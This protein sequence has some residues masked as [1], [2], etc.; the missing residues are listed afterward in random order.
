MEENPRFEEIFKED[1]PGNLARFHKPHCA[2]LFKQLR[3]E[4]GM[5]FLKA[6]IVDG[7]TDDTFS[8]FDLFDQSVFKGHN[9]K[10]HEFLASII[11]ENENE[12]LHLAV[13]SSNLNWIEILIRDY[14][15]D[16]NAIIDGLTPLFKVHSTPLVELKF[17]RDH[18][19]NSSRIIDFL[20]KS[21]ADPLIEVDAFFSLGPYQVH[22]NV[23]F[24]I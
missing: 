15:A 17:N 1:L 7:N 18:A 4:D 23:T 8:V 12:L 20:L 21:G 11:N 16:P 24:Q 19:A 13:E 6:F 3:P 5:S 10:N 2:Q 14:H 9:F 22:L